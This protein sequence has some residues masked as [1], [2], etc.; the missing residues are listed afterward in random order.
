MIDVIVPVGPGHES[1]VSRAINSI[2]IAS[3]YSGIE[4][5]IIKV[6]DTHGNLGRSLARNHGVN[7]A[8]AEWLFF[9]DADDL[10]HPEGL[11]PVRSGYINDF[12]AVFGLTTE[13]VD[14]NILT[15]YQVPQIDDYEQ[16]IS[17]DPFMTVKM[18]HFV[19]REVALTLP[20]NLDMDAGEDWHYYLRLWKQY[21]CVKV[22]APL[23]IKVRGQHSTGPRS[24]TG[25]D[26]NAA[27]GALIEEARNG[28]V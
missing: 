12:D 27:V 10:I 23:F 11:E 21:N 16:L 26:W 8:E 20:F 24:A 2:E 17:H 14:G 6:D 25:T 5:R 9:L 3:D 4:A 22:N 1:V 15:R 18:G 13:L 28:A 19:R 7:R